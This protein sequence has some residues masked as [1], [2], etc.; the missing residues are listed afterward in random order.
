MLG[1]PRLA[2]ASLALPAPATTAAA[3]RAARPL[4][5]A[6]LLLRGAGKASEADSR[7]G[8]PNKARPGDT[9][10][11]PLQWPARQTK[12]GIR[13]EFETF[14][15]HVFVTDLVPRGSKWDFDGIPWQLFS[16]RISWQ[17][18]NPTKTHEM[19]RK[20]GDFRKKSVKFSEN[21]RN[22][23]KSAEIVRDRSKQG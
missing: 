6:G 14:K 18:P 4:K 20:I 21:R 13:P 17:E 3:L 23:G 10:G 11:P 1:S 16:I 22:S 8:K 19:G 2:S 9:A 5:A 7:R 12:P 15:R